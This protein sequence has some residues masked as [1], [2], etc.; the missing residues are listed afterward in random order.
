M[1]MSST[2]DSKDQDTSRLTRRVDWVSA[3]GSN[4][5]YQDLDLTGTSVPRQGDAPDSVVASPFHNNVPV[6]MDGAPR[7]QRD[8]F[9]PAR[10]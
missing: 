1:S 3:T 6:S 5:G 2:A 9:T 8:R 10:L 4:H 7:A